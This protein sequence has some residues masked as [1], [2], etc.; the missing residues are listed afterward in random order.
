MSA[1]NVNLSF[2][3]YSA[4][5]AELDIIFSAT[6]EILDTTRR[7]FIE[8][9]VDAAYSVEPIEQVIDDLKEVLRARHIVRLQQGECSIEAGFVWSDILTNIGRCSDHCSNIAG[10]VIDMADSSFNLHEEIRAFRNTDGVFKE[11]FEEYSKKYQ[12]N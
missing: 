3:W 1:S 6:G 5:V 8:N 4:A 7:A 11:R 10:C 12:L 9:D 2:G